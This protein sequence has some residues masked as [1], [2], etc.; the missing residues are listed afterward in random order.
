MAEALRLEDVRVEKLGDDALVSGR[1]PRKARWP[2]LAKGRP[3]G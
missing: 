3:R 2:S 1:V